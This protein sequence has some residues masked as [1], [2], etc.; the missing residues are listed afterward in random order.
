MQPLPKP[1]PAR[2][3]LVPVAH[4]R[5]EPGQPRAGA[6][7]SGRLVVE[8]VHGESAATAC[9][10][11]T[12]LRL[13]APRARGASVWIVAASHGG[14]LV[15]G[16]AV[17]LDVTVAR[18]AAAALGTQAETK[19]YR[20]TGAPARQ[21]VHARV[22]AGGV[23][24]MLPEPLCP[25]AGARYDGAQRF[26]LALGASLVVVE[27]VTAGRAARGERWA[28]AAHQTRTEVAVAGRLVVAD[29]LRLVAGEGPPLADR[30]P[31]LELLATAVVLGP[32]FED[33]AGAALDAIGAL[34]ARGDAGVLAAA[35]PLPGGALLRFAARSVE[36]GLAAIREHL[37]FARGPLGG[38]PFLERP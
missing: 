26:D 8:R 1:R 15:A 6:G 31:G 16:D 27:A 32:A 17:D 20:S 23:L 9:A 34:P 36:A 29:A 28:F 37:A 38:C 7:G 22:E 4:G 12:P 10:S 3:L 33:G 19:V 30:L 18:G 5:P 21:R 13:F 11:S 14:G 35:S 24:A 25:Y 2:D